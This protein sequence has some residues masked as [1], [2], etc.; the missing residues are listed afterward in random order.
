[1]AGTLHLAPEGNGKTQTMLS[2]LRRAL[3]SLA[4]FPRVWMLLATR[5]QE[6]VFRERLALDANGQRVHFHIDFFDFYGLNAHLLRMAGQPV[7]RLNEAT[8]FS[9]LR[10]LLEDMHA[11]DELRVFHGIADTR[12]FVTVLATFIDELKQNGI[13]AEAYQEAAQNPK[14]RELAAIFARYQR[15]LR[16]NRLADLEGEGWL[17]LAK[18]REQPQIAA[19][20][21]MLLVDGFDQFTRVQA[22]LLAALG[23][24]IPQLHI[25]LTQTGN[26]PPT[27]RSR[28]ARQR[29]ESAFAEAG[30]TLRLEKIAPNSTRHVDLRRLSQHF[31]ADYPSSDSSEALKLI[32]AP[33]PEHEAREVLRDVKRRLLAGVP[34]D[35]M[36][37]VLR[38]WELYA[39]ALGSISADFQLP[40]LMQIERPISRRAGYRCAA[41]CAGTVASPPPARSVG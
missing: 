2:L 32:A 38:D 10:R 20:T 34:P 7:R 15:Q 11:A 33:S 6:L 13:G 16:E 29:L 23:R 19:A 37:I 21:D 26:A 12:G 41:G 28:I 39:P 17:A 25:T 24:A 5:R 22:Q 27:S 3:R 8:R 4:D 30:V 35:D 1:M 31:Y 14:D 9:L 40:L 36:L 18:L